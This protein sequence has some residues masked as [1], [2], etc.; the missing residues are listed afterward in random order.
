MC[1]TVAS[2]SKSGALW[3]NKTCLEQKGMWYAHPSKVDN[4]YQLIHYKYSVW[5]MVNS[6]C[7]VTQ[8]VVLTEKERDVAFFS[9]V[10]LILTGPV[11]SMVPESL[12]W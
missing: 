6:L 1:N 3:A 11:S 4:L 2:T 10:A 12:S 9:T 7:I 5:L 8:Y